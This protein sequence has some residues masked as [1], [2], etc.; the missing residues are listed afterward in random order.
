MVRRCNKRS[1]TKPPGTRRL[2]ADRF[3]HSPRKGFFAT[4]SVAAAERAR[5]RPLSGGECV[6][7]QVAIN[8]GTNLYA[9]WYMDWQRK[10]ADIDTADYPVPEL[11]GT[12]QSLLNPDVRRPGFE[13]DHHELLA[14]AAPRAFLLIGGSQSEDAGG[15]SDDPETWGYFNRAKDAYKLLGIAYRLQFASTT[16]GH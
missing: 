10:F 8:G 11:R 14:L 16:Q 15:D 9:R 4:P 6:D 5:K 2:H 7:L 13:H 1:G 12:V 3:G